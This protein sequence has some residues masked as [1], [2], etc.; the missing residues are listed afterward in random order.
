MELKLEKPNETMATL[1]KKIGYRIQGFDEKEEY[2][3]VKPLAPN[4]YPRFHIYARKNEGT[5]H[6][7]LHLDQKRASY[8]G[9]FAHSGEYDG[10]VVEKE[11]K[12][13]INTLNNL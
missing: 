8:E 5:F 2:N 4:G 7:S 10:D 11:A 1:A 3:M 6:I 9:S 13:I 12:K